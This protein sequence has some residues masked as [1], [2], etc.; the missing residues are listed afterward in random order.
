MRVKQS[1]WVN[2]SNPENLEWLIVTANYSKG[3]G[4]YDCLPMT[5]FSVFDHFCWEKA[6]RNLSKL[7]YARVNLADCPFYVPIHAK[8]ELS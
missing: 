5:D 2:R 7:G 8:R 6:L 3:R 4:W 1:F